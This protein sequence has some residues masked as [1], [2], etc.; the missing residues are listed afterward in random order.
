[1]FGLSDGLV[2]NL[3]LVGGV[4]GATSERGDVVVGGMAG[5]VAGAMSMAIG[6]YVSVRANS[7]LLERELAAERAEIEDDPAGETLELAGIYADR[8]LDRA[9]AMAIANQMMA[10]P[11][12]AL[13][14]HA[15]EELGIDPE[16]LGSPVLAAT[17]SFGSFALGAIIPVIPFLFGSGTIAI[18]I[19]FLLG[20]LAAAVLGGGLALMTKR[21]V[22]RG[23]TRQVALITLAFVVTTAIG[24]L[25][26][27]AV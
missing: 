21:S 16:E 4:A 17:A 2:S 3:S 10:D 12:T 14:A 6:E 5:L 27:A 25:V 11:E 15:R 7:E 19:S 13:Q 9:S 26:G 20:L 1:V 23:V 22:L 8:G 24:N 18:V